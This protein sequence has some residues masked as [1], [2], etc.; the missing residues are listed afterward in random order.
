MKRGVLFLRFRSLVCLVGDLRSRFEKAMSCITSYNKGRM[1]Y[2]SRREG[3]KECMEEE[4][5][6]EGVISMVEV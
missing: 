2:S 5:G 1:R 4:G 3:A 6:K